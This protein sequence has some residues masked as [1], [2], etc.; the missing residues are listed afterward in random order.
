M[1]LTEVAFAEQAEAEGKPALSKHQGRGE[2]A[3]AALQFSWQRE[4]RH[5]TKTGL[6]GAFLE[7]RGCQ[8]V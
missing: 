3:K 2:P 6:R 7:S 4:K 1:R 5:T 8:A